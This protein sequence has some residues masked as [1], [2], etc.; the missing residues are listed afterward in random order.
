MQ[1]SNLVTSQEC[2]KQKASHPHHLPPERGEQI[3]NL[4]N[5]AEGSKICNL[6]SQIECKHLKFENSHLQYEAE[7]SK[8]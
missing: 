1:E 6:K 4:Y 8:I 5:E 7:I 2:S 3:S